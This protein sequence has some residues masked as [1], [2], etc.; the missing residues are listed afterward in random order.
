MELNDPSL[1]GSFSALSS[2]YAIG[3]WP[4]SDGDV[5][6]GTSVEV[7][8]ST[9]KMD[10]T[11]VVFIWFADNEEQYTSD[12]IPLVD[13]G[14]TWNGASVKDAYNSHMLNVAGDWGV[15][16]RFFK[17]TSE[18]GADRLAIRA[19]SFHPFVIPEVPFGVIGSLTA[20]VL[21]LFVYQK[22]F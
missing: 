10:A 6:L 9:T 16:A 13:N 2:G 18:E 1:K 12:M 15:Q 14:D 11:H 4:Y 21:A 20:M 19:I 7:R 3:R 22:R 17:G 5:P 8:A